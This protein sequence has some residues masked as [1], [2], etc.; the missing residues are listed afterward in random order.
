MIPVNSLP[1]ILRAKSEFRPCTFNIN[2]T[3]TRF[4]SH[5]HSSVSIHKRSR[6][7]MLPFYTFFHLFF[8]V[9]PYRHRAFV[10]K[11]LFVQWDGWMDGW[12]EWK[13]GLQ[14]EKI[15]VQ[16]RPR[17]K[18][19][20]YCILTSFFKLMSTKKN[21]FLTLFLFPNYLLPNE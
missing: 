13:R 21:V 15:K 2:K 14:A 6:I 20:G 1:W 9:C 8:T 10:S 7:F 5:Y 4:Y 17:V 16:R 3:W 11:H 19:S 12:I 18:S